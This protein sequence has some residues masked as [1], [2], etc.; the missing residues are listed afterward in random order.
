[1]S[2][3]FKTQDYFRYKRLGKRWRRPKGRHSKLRE[4]RG[5]SGILPSIGRKEKP[6]QVPVIVKNEKELQGLDKET[7]VLI[8]SGVGIKKALLILKKAEEFGIKILNKKSVKRSEFALKKNRETKKKLAEEK[9]TKEKE[10]KKEVP[11]KKEKEES[12]KEKEKL[13]EKKKEVSAKAEK[14]DVQT[15]ERDDIK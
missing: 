13:S 6:K 5:G 2:K 11:K 4:K 7:K 15:A 14:D 1:M 12:K 8:S 3:R 9:K 10:K